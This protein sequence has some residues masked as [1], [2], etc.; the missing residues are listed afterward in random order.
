ME[1]RMPLLG[2]LQKGVGPVVQS[3]EEKWKE[4]GFRE[5]WR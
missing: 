1:K 4:S 2:V 3:G 5:D